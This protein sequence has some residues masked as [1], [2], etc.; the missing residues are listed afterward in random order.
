MTPDRK[1]FTIGWDWYGATIVTDPD[2]LVARLAGATMATP[3]MIRAGRW[4]ALWKL[5]RGDD[6][7][8]TVAY[9]E[10]R[11][12]E[13]YFEAKSHSPELVPLV[14]EW[15]PQ[16]RVA[17]VD[18]RI[19]FA[20]DLWWDVIEADLKLYCETKN[21]RM[22]PVGPHLQPHMGGRTWNGGKTASWQ[23]C[24][25]LYE[26]GCELRLP[27]RS[28][29]RLEA[30]VRPPSKLKAHYA[31]L[32]VQEVLLDNAFVRY[33]VPR[34]GIDLGTAVMATVEKNRSDLD[35]LMDVFARQYLATFKLLAE[36]Y[37][38][39]QEFRDELQRRAELDAEIRN[40]N[41]NS[42]ATHPWAG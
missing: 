9:T 14:R 40:Y 27:T 11:P 17:R 13:P 3:E 24:V 18:A 39:M 34:I 36:R 2:S 21:V 38:S 32:T 42:K 30:K 22:D 1:E 25:T 12:D 16:H 19:D 33:L 8:C 23:R 37:E 41:R 4:D 31:T 15:H 20:D 35:K 7:I 29:I 28:P 6:V 26:K 10:D 5:H